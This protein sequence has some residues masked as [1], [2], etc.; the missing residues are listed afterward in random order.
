[1]TKVLWRQGMVLVSLTSFLC[2]ARSNPIVLSPL[3]AFPMLPEMTPLQLFL[4]AVLLFFLNF[5]L[6]LLVLV[7]VLDWF[8]VLVDLRVAD[9]LKYNL[10]VT[11]GG[12]LADL[13]GFWS[14]QSVGINPGLFAG[15]RFVAAVSIM[16]GAL[17]LF[18]NFFLA[19]WLLDLDLQDAFRVGIV[20][21]T[22]TTPWSLFVTFFFGAV[23][24]T[25][26]VIATAY[27]LCKTAP[28]EGRRRRFLSRFTIVAGVAFY[29]FLVLLATAWVAST[30]EWRF[31]PD[32]SMGAGEW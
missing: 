26:I 15:F 31:G 9:V 30:A 23:L 10:W 8:G 14:V 24:F 3:D 32:S 2:Y 19:R 13:F 6:D 27:K 25:L 7:L 12:W 16:A 29:W 4:H 11:A 20:F 17:I 21:A 18:W 28:P 22:F 5:G 1:M